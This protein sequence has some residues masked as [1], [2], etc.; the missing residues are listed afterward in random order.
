[1]GSFVPAE[2]AELTPVDAVCARVGAGDW[3]MRGIST[4]MAEM[5]E[6]SSILASATPASLVIID[7]LG[8]GTSTY[9]GFGL[10]AAIGEHLALQTRAFTLFATHFHELTALEQE[11]PAGASPMLAARR[12]RGVRGHLPPYAAYP[13]VRPPQASHATST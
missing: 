3:A 2:F 8:R 9:D 7:E 5:L 10:A 1:M 4:F 6:A 12:S 13:R 11:L